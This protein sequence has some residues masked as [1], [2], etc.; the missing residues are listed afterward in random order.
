[1]RRKKEIDYASNVSEKIAPRPLPFHAQVF[2]FQSQL[3]W[4]IFF[5]QSSAILRTRKERQ[6]R[7]AARQSGSG[8]QVRGGA[9]PFPFFFSSS[10]E[11][12]QTLS[13]LP[14]QFAREIH[15]PDPARDKSAN[16]ARETRMLGW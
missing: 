4:H 11:N 1:M 12:S 3:T 2:V 7:H 6:R 8:R 10:I 14:S 16:S 9:P 5:Q 15:S 13:F